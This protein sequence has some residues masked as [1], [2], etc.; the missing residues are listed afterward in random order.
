MKPRLHVSHCPITEEDRLIKSGVA[1]RQAGSVLDWK[2]WL[3][4]MR[5]SD[6]YDADLMYWAQVQRLGGDMCQLDAVRLPG[7]WCRSMW[8]YVDLVRVG[9][10][11][12]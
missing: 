9:G 8:W 5:E 6:R 2:Q 3:D 4:T 12:A 10:R 7:K 1:A 11:L